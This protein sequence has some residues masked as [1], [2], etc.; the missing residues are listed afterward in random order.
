[1]NQPSRLLASLAAIALALVSTNTASQ[2]ANVDTRFSTGIEYS[3]GTYGGTDDI[4]EVYVPFTLNVGFDRISFRVTAPYL[5][6]T[7]VV[8]PETTDDG[9]QQEPDPGTRATESGLGDVIGSITLYD[10]YY[11]D[12]ADVVVDVTGQIKFGTADETKGLGTGENDY[13]LRF[14][15]YRVLRPFRAAG[16]RRLS[17]SWQ[18]SRS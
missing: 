4:E 15:A 13:T 9:S 8:T 17:V 16:F 6:V 18:A 11:S 7:E 5:R 12:S 1:M 10:L 3:S 14:H 2:P